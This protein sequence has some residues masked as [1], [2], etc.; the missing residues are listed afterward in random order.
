MFVFTRIKQNISLFI[1][2]IFTFYLVLLP[3]L[4][5]VNGQEAPKPKPQDWHINGIMAALDDRDPQVQGYALDK[6]AQYEAQDLKAVLKKPE[7]IAQQAA[8]L[9]KDKNVRAYYDGDSSVPEWRWLTYFLS[10]GSDEAKT[11]LK[12]VG[13]PQTTPEKLTHS[14]GVKTLNLFLKAWEVS[15]SEGL[16]ELKDDLAK[17][18]AIITAYK[19]IRWQPQDITLLGQ[20]YKNLKEVNSTHAET[21]QSVIINLQGW[22]WFFNFRNI[23]LTHAAFWLALIFAYPKSPQ[24]QA[25]F[26]W[27]PWVRRIAGMGY[28]G[29]LLTWVPFL[30]R[31]LLEPFQ[32]SLLADARLDNFTEATYFPESCVKPPATELEANYRVLSNPMDL[33]LISQM[34]SQGEHPDLFR[35][36]E[37]QYNLMAW[38][39]KREWK[40]DFPL[41]KFSQ[42]VYQQRIN[43]E[44]AILADEFDQEVFSM[45]DQKYKMVVSRQWKNKDGETKKEWYFRHDKIMEFFIV[46]N[47]LGDSTEAKERRS[48]HMDDPRFRGVY[49]LLAKLLP[50]EQAQ[51]LRENLIQYAV[52]TKDHTVM[53]TYVQLLRSR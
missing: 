38:E 45:E 18:I 23:I 29:F 26:F 20:H 13:K 9:L 4:T 42:K 43:D 8:K 24:I 5:W 36:Q 52:D 37:Q 14:E 11:L 17:Q 25:I 48:K 46:Q 47:F 15:T 53:D 49:F 3:S 41:K 50:L 44:S 16:K 32:L 27:N 12:W 31:K 39:Y 28:V 22:R 21:I 34:L 33:T 30:R 10:G 19:N 40:H 51:E 6:L 2:F 1:V 35:L 7:D